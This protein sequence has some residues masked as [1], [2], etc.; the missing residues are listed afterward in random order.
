MKIKIIP[1]PKKIWAKSLA[2]ILGT[3]LTKAGHIIVSKTAD[4][5]ICIGG[6]GTILYANY[7]NQLQGSVLGIGGDKSYIC[8][9]RN[10]CTNEEVLSLLQS[11]KREKIM[12]LSCT[13]QKR[14]FTVL[15]DVVVHASNF[16]V[17]E[18]D[19]KFNDQLISFEGDGLI[20]SS[21][22][23]SAAYAYSA[24]GEKLNPDDK[25]MV[26]V[27]ICPYKRMLPPRTLPSGVTIEIKAG[28][29]CALIIDGI[30][31][32]HLKGENVSVEKGS[33]IIFFSGVGRYG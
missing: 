10:G 29:D 28:N 14:K 20:V 27:P 11:S 1:N 30:F 19:L 18:I 12:A 8:Q 21:P 33:D 9:L 26:V 6:D 5:T 23:G 2:K 16:R 22:L 7:K 4:A 17:V 32:S 3:Y 24:G 31:V 13:V 25:R 15:N